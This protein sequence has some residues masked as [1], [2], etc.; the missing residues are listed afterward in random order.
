MVALQ[1]VVTMLVRQQVEED[2]GERSKITAAMP[3]EGMVVLLGS[4]EAY[5]LFLIQHT[6]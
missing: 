5:L 6:K 2:M 3:A 1:V 4:D